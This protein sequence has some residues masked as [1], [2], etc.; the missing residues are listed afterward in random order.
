MS[1]LP[2]LSS[3]AL[4]HGLPPR[5]IKEV[6]FKSKGQK[7]RKFCFNIIIIKSIICLMRTSTFWLLSAL[8][9]LKGSSIVLTT[10]LINLLMWRWSWILWIIAVCMCVH[11]VELSSFLLPWHWLIRVFVSVRRKQVFLQLSPA[12]WYSCRDPSHKSRC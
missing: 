5:L 9:Q 10:H 3:L 8:D 6:E 11:V 4:S 1:E 2:E 7:V 12:G